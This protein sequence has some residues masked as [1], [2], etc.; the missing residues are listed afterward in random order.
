MFTTRTPS[1]SSSCLRDASAAC[2]NT[3]NLRA[4]LRQ[5]EVK[6]KRRRES[7]TT[8]S[9]GRRTGNAGTIRQQGIIGQHRANA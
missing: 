4:R 8:R 1:F 6:G 7:R 5:P 3:R 9:N 2:V